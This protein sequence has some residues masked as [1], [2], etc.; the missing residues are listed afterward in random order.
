MRSRTVALNLTQCA[1][2]EVFGEGGRKRYWCCGA[3]G[4]EGAHVVS[5]EAKISEIRIILN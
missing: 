2:P 5:A 1:L 4:S 3:L